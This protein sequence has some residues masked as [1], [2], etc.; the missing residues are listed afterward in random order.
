[1][2]LRPPFGGDPGRI[3]TW[4]NKYIQQ[5]KYKITFPNL[6]KPSPGEGSLPDVVLIP[7]ST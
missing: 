3:I 2:N 7:Q 6:P 4:K 5:Q 1:M